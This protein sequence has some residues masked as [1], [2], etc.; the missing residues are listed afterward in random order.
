MWVFKWTECLRTFRVHSGPVRVYVE[1][2]P[3][4]QH[5]CKRAEAALTPINTLNSNLSERWKVNV[6]KSSVM[7]FES[8]FIM[9]RSFRRASAR[10]RFKDEGVLKKTTR[11]ERRRIRLNKQTLSEGNTKYQRGTESGKNRH[12]HSHHNQPI[13][14]HRSSL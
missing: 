13:S 10:R 8:Q 4:P 12:H 11:V 6:S 2:R 7:M 1:G 9:R 3:S 14:S 5:S